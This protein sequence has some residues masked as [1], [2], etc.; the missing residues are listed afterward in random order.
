MRG[1]VRFVREHLKVVGPCGVVLESTLDDAEH[2][3]LSTRSYVGVLD[4]EIGDC[5]R[6]PLVVMVEVLHGFSSVESYHI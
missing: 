6:V 4:V 3:I 1:L 2:V 5:L